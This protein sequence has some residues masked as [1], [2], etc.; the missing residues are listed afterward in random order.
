[1]SCHSFFFPFDIYKLYYYDSVLEL[2]FPVAHSSFKY[3]MF[4][5]QGRLPI[6]TTKQSVL[7]YP[8]L[9]GIKICIL[10]FFSEVSRTKWRHNQLKFEFCSQF[11]FS[12]LLSVIIDFKLF[13]I[14]SCCQTR[15]CSITFF[16]RIFYLLKVLSGNYHWPK[17]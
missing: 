13:V 3:K 16:M 8:E 2:G 14:R 10:V 7:F 4:L 17:S 9:S 15:L 5:S 1:M 6:R 11:P 12:F